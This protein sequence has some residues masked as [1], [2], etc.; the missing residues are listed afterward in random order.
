MQSKPRIPAHTVHAS[1][2]VMDQ[3]PTENH[4]ESTSSQSRVN[5][6]L[7]VGNDQRFERLWWRIELVTWGVLLLLLGCALSGILGRGPLAQKKVA[8]A[9]GALA[10]RFERVGRYKTPAVM[11]VR[12]EPQLFRNGSAQVWISNVV[13]KNLGVQRTMPLPSGAYSGENGVLYTFAAENP[14]QAMQI[15]FAM[16]PQSAGVF[17][18][19][20]RSDPTHDLFLTSITVP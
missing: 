18:E 8:S 20:V 7:S 3:Q 12:V 14:S 10:V 16:E 4:P 2:A 19:E 5:D 15:E 11:I 13:I 1:H 17:H 9:D 6:E